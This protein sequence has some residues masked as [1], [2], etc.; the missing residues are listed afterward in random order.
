MHAP[1]FSLLMLHTPT[2]AHEIIDRHHHKNCPAIHPPGSLH[3]ITT[4]F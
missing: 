3:V 1:S 4:I 2:A